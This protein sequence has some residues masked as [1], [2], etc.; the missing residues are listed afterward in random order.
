MDTRSIA[1]E[2][3][4]CYHRWD[5]WLRRTST[6]G[7]EALVSSAREWVA[8]MGWG[9][10]VHVFDSLAT[11]N[12]RETL[13]RRSAV[14]GPPLLRS[15]ANFY[16]ELCK[17]TL[18][19]VLYSQI[20]LLF[21]PLSNLM[22]RLSECLAN[23]LFV[24]RRSRSEMLVGNPSF[25]TY[26]RELSLATFCRVSCFAEALRDTAGENNS[27]GCRLPPEEVQKFHDSLPFL[28]KVF[29]SGAGWLV[30]SRSTLYVI[31]LPQCNLDDNS[32]LHSDNSPAVVWVDGISEYWWHGLQVDSKIIMHP[33]S[34]T[35]GRGTRE[36]N[37][38]IRRFIFERMSTER[39]LDQPGVEVIH[40]DTD[41]GHRRQLLRLVIG[42]SAPV[43][44]VR[45]VCPSTKR[46][47]VLRVPPTMMSCSEAIA[48]TFGMSRREYQPLVQS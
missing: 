5:T 33:E 15:I 41:D 34:L 24:K 42:G 18:D 30:P 9:L 37:P 32:K 26:L 44:A 36:P 11:A 21:Q 29:E 7:S 12:V 16:D 40:A 45:V 17:F 46:T 2:I 19:Q 28:R 3:R 22:R 25:A 43:V 8:S 20:F 13:L 31:P 35:L 10:G 4:R 38:E 47:H 48:W 1:F 6:P 27:S 39:L 14:A 23:R